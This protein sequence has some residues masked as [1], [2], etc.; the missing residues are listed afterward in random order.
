V[1]VVI[2]TGNGPDALDAL[3][4]LTPASRFKPGVRGDRDPYALSADCFLV[5]N[6]PEL[7]VMN[8][9][10]K[11]S[12]LYR[13]SPSWIEEGDWFHE[14]RRLR[15]R[16]SETSIPA[17]SDL[18]QPDGRIVVQDVYVG[19][20]MEGIARGTI[21]RLLILE[22]LPKPVNYTGSMDPISFGGSY[23]LNRVLGTVP[24]E[25]DGSVHAR[26]PALRSL[27]LV[28]LDENDCSVKRML[29]FMTVMPGE[30]SSCIGCHEQRTTT[31][32][33]RP[34]RALQRAPSTIQP[35]A[36]TPDVFDYPRDIQPVWDKYCVSCH[37]ATTYEGRVLM[38]GD[39]GPMFSHSYYSL[40]V[41]L[42]MADGRD[43]ARGNYP[44]YSIGSGA[45][46][47]L[48]KVDGRHYGVEVSSDELRMIKLWIDAS[49]TFPGTY[50]ALG[51]GMIG[52]Y[53]E[54]QYKTK[55]AVDVDSWPSMVAARQ[56]LTDRCARCH[57][58]DMKLPATPK[59]TLGLRLHH[60][61]YGEGEPRY[62][63]PPWIR[64]YGDGSLRPGSLQ[65]LRA[66]GD[67]R[68]RFSRHK[69]YN[70]THPERSLQLL[71]PLSQKVGGLGICGDVFRHQDDP[72]FRVL[73]TAIEDAKHYLDRI[74]RFSMPNFRPEPEYVREMIRFGALPADFDVHADSI[75]VYDVD[76]RYWQSLWHQPATA[77]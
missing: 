33:R 51:S 47:L 29:S 34:V 62:W 4:V 28:A 71:A 18:T 43:L 35:I 44:P 7:L 57:V 50:A 16:Q 40:S 5:A 53:A 17:K 55:P 48:D 8:R 15:A 14:P 39:R 72:G 20:N 70:L 32:E 25:P 2:K 64:E 24:V 12:L 1:V 58:G 67:P 36:G 23:T 10:G 38:T 65:W 45:S 69:I 21:K 13:L 60:L 41:H 6:G 30:V 61:V 9:R 3:D 27:Q 75:D 31:H 26:V 68:L 42:Q 19:R 66:Y 46:Y 49:A 74:T 11:T 52:P 56:V 22:N 54:L 76:R 37:D 73:L 63:D 77:R 59:D